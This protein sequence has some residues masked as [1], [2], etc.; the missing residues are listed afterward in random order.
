MKAVPLRRAALSLLALAA[1]CDLPPGAQPPPP[2]LARGP[3]FDAGTDAAPPRLQDLPG[4]KLPLPD[5]DAGLGHLWFNVTD[6]DTLAAVP[7]RVIFRPPPAAGFADSITS[8][9]FDVHSAGGAMGAVVGP[10]VLG[11]PEGVLLVNGQGRVPVPPGTYS[12]FI[13]RGPEYEAVETTVTIAAGD[14]QTVNAQLTRSVDTR[15][16][17]SADLHVHVNRSKDSQ[18]AADR[19]IISLVTNDVEI[20]VPTDHNINTDLAPEL[21]ALGYGQYAGTLVGNEFNF[22]EGHAGAYPVLYDGTKPDGGSTTYQS[23]N[24]MTG[25]CDA[26]IVGINCMDTATGFATM[27]QQ[28]PGQT[29]VAVN[30]PYWPTADLGYFTNIHWGAGT[31]NGLGPL[32]TAG[33]FDALEVLNGYW[34]LPDALNNLVADWFY[35]VGHGYRVTALGNSDSHRINWVRAGFPRTWLRLPIDKPSD[36]TGA[37]LSDAIHH[38]RAIA[39]TGPF[40]TL[41]ADGAQIGDTVIPAQSGQVLV[42]VTVDAPGWMKVDT[43]NVYVNGV[44]RRS[45]AVG[46]GQRP[47][48][49]ASFAQALTPG[50]D[51]WIVAFASGQ[52]P[53]P[54]DVVGEY[55]LANGAAMLPWAITNPVF[56]DG[57]GDGA[58]MPPTMP[59]P[60]HA[61]AMRPAY[62]P[63]PERLN[64]P[65]ECEPVRSGAPLP[66][67]PLPQPE[68][69]L[70]PLL[71][72]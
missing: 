11:S 34:T 60:P 40:I 62:E 41:A 59:L 68:R 16:W 53:L 19:R 24:P 31:A 44:I 3:T 9:T 27:K 67:E 64:V 36:I 17:L 72:P 48:F 26:P 13:T 6:G 18:L 2:D 20:I 56:V 15:G 38:Q 10:G 8:G 47:V 71:Y 23:P 46:A 43:V 25:M 14:S 66:A 57:D 42:T 45:F 65:P 5:G 51:A 22:H 37:L 28:V 63:N 55:S 50:E 49:S 32:A 52:E 69:E 39:S 61:G 70:M 35:L 54:L 58:W 33:S 12:L 30:H 21:A 1:S 4:N 7:S 29:I